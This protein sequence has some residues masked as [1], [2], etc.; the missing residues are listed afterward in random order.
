ML[1]SAQWWH[2]LTAGSADDCCGWRVSFQL[3]SRHTS[4]AASCGALLL[5]Q[6]ATGYPGLPYKGRLCIT[7]A[8]RI[9]RMWAAAAQHMG[10]PVRPRTR[11][12][13]RR[14]WM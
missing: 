13:R 9:C 1:R 14:G 4:A 8:R 3:T 10:L 12:R 11:E 2:Q 7:C 5:F 6:D